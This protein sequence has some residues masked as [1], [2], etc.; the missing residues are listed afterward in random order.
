MGASGASG[1][2]DFGLRGMDTPRGMPHTEI[3]TGS[4]IIIESLDDLQ[5]YQ[6]TLKAT[7]VRG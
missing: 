1:V 7:S 4:R 2:A 5:V 3:L 6:K